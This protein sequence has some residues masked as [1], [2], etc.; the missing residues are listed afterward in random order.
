MMR[1]SSGRSGQPH[2][3]RAGGDDAVRERDRLRRCLL[4]GVTFDS[5]GRSR[6]LPTPR[7]TSTLRCFARR[8]KPAREPPDDLVL[9][10]A[11]L[12]CVD[13]R[14]AE[15]QRRLRH[16]FRFLDHL[17]GVQQRLGRNAADVEADAAEHR[18]A[19]DQRDLQAE[20]GGTE[21]GRVAAGAGAEHDDVEVVRL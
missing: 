20:V 2:R 18:P 17:R 14:L 12:G 7:S 16:R 19:L 1:G 3:F 15:R 10:L 21:R 8:R 4:S 5:C 11:Q 6:N 13:L 9:P